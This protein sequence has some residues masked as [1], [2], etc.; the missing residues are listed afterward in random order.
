MKNNR[1]VVETEAIIFVIYSRAIPLCHCRNWFTGII[2]IWIMREGRLRI[3][4]TV[5]NRNSKWTFLYCGMICW[6]RY[7]IRYCNMYL[8][9]CNRDK[10]E[11]F[12]KWRRNTWIVNWQ[13]TPAKWS[14]KLI[15][16][17]MVRLSSIL[18]GGLWRN[19][20]ACTSN[21]RQG[22]ISSRCVRTDPGYAGADYSLSGGKLCVRI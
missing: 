13:S 21:R 11:I 9:L 2:T 3:R 10:K 6:L 22:W 20:W 1:L 12:V 7:N 18:D 8:L 5:E 19:L 14:V 17:Y 16:G 4:K 15:S